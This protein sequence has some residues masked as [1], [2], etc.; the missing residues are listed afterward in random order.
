VGEP[1]GILSGMSTRSTV[2]QL[3]ITLLG[4]EPPVWRR[5][6]IPSG[7][8]LARVHADF[9]AVMGWENDH[10]HQF[11]IGGRRYGRPDPDF[12]PVLGKPI[13]DERKA[14]LGSFVE[15]GDRFTYEYDF[16]DSWEHEIVVE[17]IL[18][19]GPGSATSRCLEGAGACPPED[20]GGWPGYAHFLEAMADPQHPGHDDQSAWIGGRWDPERFNLDGAN[21]ALRMSAAG[22]FR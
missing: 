18:P 3:T 15:K 1:R 13:Q 8:T 9:Q 6:Q 4:V 11:E 19:A 14:R 16:G 22:R 5:I 12:V 17:Q 7:V 20:V 2:H 21:E 10:L